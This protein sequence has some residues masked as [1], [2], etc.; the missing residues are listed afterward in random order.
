MLQDKFRMPT[1]VTNDM[2]EKNMIKCVGISSN[3]LHKT[4]DTL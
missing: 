3:R 2:G 1:N 4:P